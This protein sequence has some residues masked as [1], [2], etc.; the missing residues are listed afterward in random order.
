MDGGYHGQHRCDAS[1]ERLGHLGFNRCEPA[2]QEH[3]KM[4]RKSIGNL[5][6]I[7]CAQG[8][9]Q[10][11]LPV[12]YMLTTRAR[13]PKSTQFDRRVRP[14]NLLHKGFHSPCHYALRNAFESPHLQ[15]P[16]SCWAPRSQLRKNRL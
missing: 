11:L 16:P 2:R 6:G 7:R 15:R 4:V 13:L 12:S 14:S 5:T 1:K 10:I 8:A 3:Q 9:G